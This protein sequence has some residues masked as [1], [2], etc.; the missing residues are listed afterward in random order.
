M[1]FIHWGV[2]GA[3]LCSMFGVMVGQWVPDIMIL[4]ELVAAGCADLVLL[5]IKSAIVVAIGWA[6]FLLWGAGK[7]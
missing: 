3:I 1:G 6:I 7:P 5:L 2:G 4:A